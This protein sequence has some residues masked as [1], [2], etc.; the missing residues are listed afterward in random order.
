MKAVDLQCCM[1]AGGSGQEGG[2]DWTVAGNALNI[3]LL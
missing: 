1:R 3:L 2:G